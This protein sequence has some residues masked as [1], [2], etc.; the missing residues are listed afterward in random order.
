MKI[1]VDAGHYGKYNRSP[2]NKAYYES[3]MNWK[4]HN[5]LKKYLEEYGVEVIT[6]REDKNVDMEVFARGQAS[7]GCDLLLSVHSNAVGSGVNEAI[8][9]P[10]VYVPLNGTGDE[11]GKKLAE[12]IEKTMGTQQKGKCESKKGNRGDYYGVIRGATA[13]GVPGLILEHS[14]HTNNRIANW[15]LVDKNLD[16]LAKAEAEVI[17]NHYGLEKERNTVNIEITVLKKGMKGEE[18]KALQALLTGYGY[19]F[20]NNGKVYGIDGSFG[21]ATLNAVKKYQADNGLEVDGSVG[22]KTWSKLLGV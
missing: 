6:T 16:K 2:A 8:D 9:Y 18:V 17:A 22:R 5:L 20:E 19:K 11:L 7:A 15:L 14:F 3:D 21:G 4:L 1:C 13:V 10:V 12:C